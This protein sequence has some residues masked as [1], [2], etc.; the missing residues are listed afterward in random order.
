ML[1]GSLTLASSLSRLEKLKH[2][3][4]NFYQSS[5]ASF[6]FGI[7][8]DAEPESNR[9]RSTPRM[10]ESVVVSFALASKKKI[11]RIN[12]PDDFQGFFSNIAFEIHKHQTSNAFRYFVED[13]VF[14]KLG[15]DTV[16]HTGK[17]SS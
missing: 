14:R 1:Q 17:K 4:T 11:K 13:K 10:I 8:S 12:F 3:L 2:F 5:S 9:I 15:Y 6:T 16:H 7:F